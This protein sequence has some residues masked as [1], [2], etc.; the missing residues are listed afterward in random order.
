[1]HGVIYRVPAHGGKATL[2]AGGEALRPSTFAGANGLKLH[3]G[4][5]W[6]TNLDKGTV[7]RIPVTA[8]GTAGKIQV[9]ATGM[10][11]RPGRHTTVTGCRTTPLNR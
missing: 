11:S 10:P 6:A 2:W 8:R 4:A 7:L 9:H 1:M 5:V 3:N